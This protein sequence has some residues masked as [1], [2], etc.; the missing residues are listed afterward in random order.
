M[1]AP[2]D[3]ERVP[4]RSAAQ[5]KGFSD[6]KKSRDIRPRRG[7]RKSSP[8]PDGRHGK[9]GRP[10]R[11]QIPNHRFRSEQS[12]QLW[13]VCDLRAGAVP[14]PLPVA[15]FARWLAIWRNSQEQFIIPVPAQ[16]RTEDDSWYRGTDDAIFQNL[17]FLDVP[18]DGL[19][20]VFSADH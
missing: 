12:D 10:F 5:L 3:D 11:W 17:S 15:A 4:R 1:S 19:V 7:R 14:Q 8:A 6:G 16:M 2:F 9:T 13:P 20:A 18:E